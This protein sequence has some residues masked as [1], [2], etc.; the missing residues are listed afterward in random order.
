MKERVNYTLGN[1]PWNVNEWKMTEDVIG[2][3]ADKKGNANAASLKL[4]IPQITPLISTDSIKTETFTLSKSCFANST[5][6]M[7]TVS[8]NIKTQNYITVKRPPNVMFGNQIKNLSFKRDSEGNIISGTTAVV[9]AYLS[10][11]DKIA[12]RAKNADVDNLSVSNS[13]DP[14][15]DS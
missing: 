13:N 14:S 8:S 11:G 9:S 1:L 15:T 7:P 4:F 2:V 5:K 6:C 3:Y 10:L 12:V